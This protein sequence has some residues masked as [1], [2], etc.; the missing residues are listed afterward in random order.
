MSDLLK[1][2][3]T[4]YQIG[5][6]PRAHYGLGIVM[7][8]FASRSS[9]VVNEN[10]LRFDHGLLVD[11]EESKTNRRR[12]R[13]R[14]ALSDYLGR[15]ANESHE[16][17][18]N[19][20]RYE[21]QPARILAEIAGIMERSKLESIFID[22]SAFP[23]Y[24]LATVLVQLF[25]YGETLD[26]NFYYAEGNYIPARKIHSEIASEWT[27][28]PIFGATGIEN[29]AWKRGFFL[30]AGFESNKVNRLL[31][32]HE[33]DHIWILE[34]SPGFTDEYSQQGALAVEEVLAYAG[35]AGNGYAAGATQAHASD[36][37]AA[38][39]AIRS[40]WSNN[41]SSR[42]RVRW[43]MI[44]CG[45]RPHCLAMTVFALEQ[46]DIAIVCPIPGE[47]ITHDVEINGIVWAHKL[48]DKSVGHI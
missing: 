27:L 35:L 13:N 47:Y 3:S 29:P 26:Y 14:R 16:L 39:G 8:G 23:K 10:H 28:A 31:A 37:Q 2:E 38:L 45:P 21:S 11:F 30:S 9:A 18:L 17:T 5:S 42:Q 44:P 46:S 34:A 40:A 25:L 36:A 19:A 48:T 33:P 43:T 41:L 20:S 22:I 15:H 32:R 12:A 6:L 4:K 1:L 7:S 24:F